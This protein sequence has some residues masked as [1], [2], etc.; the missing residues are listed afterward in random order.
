MWK[1]PLESAWKFRSVESVLWTVLISTFLIAYFPVISGL[2]RAWARSDDY[3]HGFVIVPIAIYILWQKRETL[4]CAS[5]DGAWPGLIVA[6]VALIAY[7]VSIKGEM[8]T[9]G[10]FSM[11]F[12]LWGT[13]IFLLGFSIFKE[14]LFPL[15]ILFFMIPVPAQLVATLTIPLQLIVTKGSVWLASIIGIPIFNEG[16][17]INMT[18]CTFEVV[19]A[20]SG[21][22]SIMTLLTLG[23][24]LAYVTLRSNLLRTLL[25]VL[26]VPIAIAV[27]IFRVFVMIAVF[28]FLE[29]N[30]STG[31]LHTVLGL[32][33][34][35]I[36]LGL[37]LLAG[38]GLALCER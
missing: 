15:S 1:N 7:L 25:F 18:R 3:S 26:A 31:T 9:L 29:V 34:F 19:Q 11:I 16:N 28:H 37:F 17:V 21:L 12:F 35:G 5:F 36:A 10:S 4:R 20:C 33:V 38:K 14:S 2:I 32:V 22:R 30:L 8:Q 6:T 13:V 27:N 24:V 23:A